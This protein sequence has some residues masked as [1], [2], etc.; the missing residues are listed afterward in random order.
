MLVITP[1]ESWSGTETHPSI[2]TQ[3]KVHGRRVG[4]S[5][6]MIFVAVYVIVVSIALEIFKKG[7]FSS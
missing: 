7:T 6:M 1:L 3:N 5:L 2:K 4:D